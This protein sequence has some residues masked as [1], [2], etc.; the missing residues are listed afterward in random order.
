MW[1]KRDDGFYR[2]SLQLRGRTSSGECGSAND[3]F[4]AIRI[5]AKDSTEECYAEI[6]DYL[7]AVLEQEEF[8]RSYSVSSW[9]GKTLSAYSRP[10]QE[11]SQSAL[12]LRCAA[13]QSA[14]SYG[15]IRSSGYAGV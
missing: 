15:A 11:G 2:R 9:E 14:S 10:A 13:P 1:G 6:L 8:P 12:C 5:T 7:C 4:A 3:A